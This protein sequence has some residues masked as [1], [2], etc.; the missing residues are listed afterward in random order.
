MLA[1]VLMK[2]V[3]VV[4]MV[5]VMVVVMVEV[6]AK[7]TVM[8][9]Q[10]RHPLVEGLREPALRV[11]GVQVDVEGWRGQLVRLPDILGGVGGR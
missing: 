10:C 2:E 8:A 3:V 6:V 5:A 11:V 7:A 4:V 1:I 9:L